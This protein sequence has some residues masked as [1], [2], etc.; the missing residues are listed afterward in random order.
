M[1]FPK[2]P[3]ALLWLRG[4]PPGMR[5]LG[6][7]MRHDDAVALV[8]R[9]YLFGARSVRVIDIQVYDHSY[10]NSGRLVITLPDDFHSR[11][12]VLDWYNGEGNLMG[13]DP[14]TDEGQAELIMLLVPFQG[15]WS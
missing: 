8:E 15:K 13:F 12:G 10:E 14:T 1:I 6:E 5:S 4:A 2:G 3:E 11:R 7:A 9:A